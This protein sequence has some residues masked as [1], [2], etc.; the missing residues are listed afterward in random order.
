MTDMERPL[1]R[2]VRAANLAQQLIGLNHED[3]VARAEA[4]GFDVR[5]LPLD[6]VITL[7]FVAA[8]SI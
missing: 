3:A 5:V 1:D 7:E 4:A 6:A 8:R 2:H